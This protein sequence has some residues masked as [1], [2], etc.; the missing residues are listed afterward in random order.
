[1][2]IALILLFIFVVHSG[3][4]IFASKICL[5]YVLIMFYLMG[6]FIFL[7]VKHPLE[8][9][10]PHVQSFYHRKRKVIL[11][12]IFS[13]AIVITAFGLA[14]FM[15]ARSRVT[16]NFNDLDSTQTGTIDNDKVITLWT[17]D[18][19]LVPLELSKGNYKISL[20]A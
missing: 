7:L 6:I 5:R 19:V 14:T 12:V 1:R 10:R 11:I 16:I 8:I 17:A 18:P 15:R 9:V 3:Y 20:E 4:L 13:L 2:M